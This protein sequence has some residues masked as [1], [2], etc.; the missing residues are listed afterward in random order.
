MEKPY[1]AHGLRDV[2]Q[3]DRAIAE[4]RRAVELDPFSLI[5]QANLGITY[6]RARR[7]DEA[8]R[9]M[10]QTLEMDPHYILG[11]FNLGMSWLPP[12]RTTMRCARCSARVSGHPGTQPET[13]LRTMGSA[14]R[15]TS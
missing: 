7:Y 12:V 13:V 2:P 14:R 11:D 15:E 1:D 5:M 9:R 10:E 3:H 8:I 4:A 6:D